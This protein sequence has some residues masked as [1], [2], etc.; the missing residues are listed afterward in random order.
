M[1]SDSMGRIVDLVRGF[2]DTTLTYVLKFGV[3][4]LC[5]A[6]RLIG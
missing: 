6:R 1:G 5:V 4:G 3:V 2:A